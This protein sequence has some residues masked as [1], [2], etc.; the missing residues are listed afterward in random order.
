[1]L[2]TGTDTGVGK[3]YFAALLLRALRARGIDAVGYKPVC[4]GSR[5][6]ARFLWEASGEAEPL[7]VINPVWLK[8]PAAPLVAAELE[9]TAIDPAQLHAHAE[10]LAARHA[11]VVCEGVG[12]WEVPLV[13]RESFGDFAVRLGWPVV[14]VAANRLGALNHTLLTAKAIA[15]GGGR[16]A[17]LVLNHLEEERDVA[18]V[19][20]RAVL[21]DWLEPPVMAELMP[22]QDWLEAETV[23][24]LAP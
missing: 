1:M 17:A 3:T 8:A 10:A 12:G 9:K 4:C 16:L 15:A 5:D 18:M 6:D 14:L 7:D 21:A 24:A 13:G 19:S 2:I 11:V 22:G 20:N 23:E